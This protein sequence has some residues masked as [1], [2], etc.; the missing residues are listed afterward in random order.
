MVLNLQGDFSTSVNS[1]KTVVT[2]NERCFL[3]VETERKGSLFPSLPHTLKMY[4]R[5]EWKKRLSPILVAMNVLL[6]WL[7]GQRSRTEQRTVCVQLK[8]DWNYF[9]P[10][11][12]PLRVTEDILQRR[13]RPFFWS[14]ARSVRKECTPSSCLLAPDEGTIHFCDCLPTWNPLYLSGIDQPLILADDQ[15]FCVKRP[16]FTTQPSSNGEEEEEVLVFMKV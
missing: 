13:I 3:V 9:P 15:S 6:S 4:V 16:G 1:K 8:K 7:F 2:L 5:T 11:V 10:L 14:V 12:T